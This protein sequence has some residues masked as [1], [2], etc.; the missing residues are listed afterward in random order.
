MVLDHNDNAYDINTK[1]SKF[2]VTGKDPR[3]TVLAKAKL[4]IEQR[5]K[6]GAHTATCLYSTV[7]EYKF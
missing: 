2:P 4:N 6:L 1:N 7:P 3:P 5:Y